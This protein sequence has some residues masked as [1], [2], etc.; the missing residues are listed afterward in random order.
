MAIIILLC[1][2][3]PFFNS[4]TIRQ[5]IMSTNIFIILVKFYIG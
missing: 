5:K 4:E 3:I 2:V 1:K